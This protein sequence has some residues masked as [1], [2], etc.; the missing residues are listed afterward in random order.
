MAETQN[1]P[2]KK[3][4][5]SE[6]QEKKETVY[7]GIFFDAKDMSLAANYFDRGSALR[8]AEETVSDV[9]E[10]SIY[11]TVEEVAI[12]A[13]FA[14]DVLP[15][16]PVSNAVKKGL[17]VKNT[18]EN[19]ADEYMGKVGGINDAISDK[20]SDIPMGTG[21][22]SG[23]AGDAFLGSRSIISKMEPN[24]TGDYFGTNYNF[25]I[26]TTGAVTQEEVKQQ[27]KDDERVSADARKVWEKEAIDETL[28]AI[29]TKMPQIKKFSLYI[30]IFGYKEDPA[31]NNFIPQTDQFKQNPNVNEFTVSQGI[32][33]KFYDKNEVLNDLGEVYAR[34]RNLNDKI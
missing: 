12:W 24:Y 4:P 26:Y 17:E 2:V 20:A 9:K 21:E 31:V 23:N 10:N 14:T 32:Y 1:G 19:T 28:N 27:K 25:R 34:F 5:E 8:S 15:D 11:K 13:K 3:S 33:E 30:D 6:N 18:V 22:D 7:F 16:N 29:K